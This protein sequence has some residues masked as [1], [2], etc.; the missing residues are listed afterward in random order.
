MP[1]IVLKILL[2]Y[3]DIKACVCCALEADMNVTTK[4]FDVAKSIQEM[5]DLLRAMAARTTGF[6]E[7]NTTSEAVVKKSDPGLGRKLDLVI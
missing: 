6:Q 4:G 7:K 3:S 2:F 1:P 5:G